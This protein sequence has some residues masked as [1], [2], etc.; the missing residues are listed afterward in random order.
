MSL[1]VNRLCAMLTHQ[2]ASPFP[3][4]RDSTLPKSLA[5]LPLLLRSL[6]N[7][8]FLKTFFLINYLLL[9]RKSEIPVPSEILFC[10]LKKEK[11]KRVKYGTTKILTKV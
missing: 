7:I 5:T 2:E 11:K 1:P 8:F 4:I 9:N 6:G 10:R 3:P